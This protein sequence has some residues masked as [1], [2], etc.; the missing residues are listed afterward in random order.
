VMDGGRIVMD[1]TPAEIFRRIDDLRSI[2]LDVPL[3][4]SLAG[5]LRDRGVPLRDDILT[6]I[7]LRAALSALTG[8]PAPADPPR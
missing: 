4:A 7:D 5:R 8:Q 3:A 6:E 1:G 2:G